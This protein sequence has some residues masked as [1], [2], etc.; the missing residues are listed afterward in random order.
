MVVK[1]LFHIYED[2]TEKRLASVEEAL[3]EPCQTSKIESLTEIVNG[4][5]L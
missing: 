5:T 1:T 4:L 3:S 2:N